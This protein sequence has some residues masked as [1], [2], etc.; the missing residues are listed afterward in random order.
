MISHSLSFLT[1]LLSSQFGSQITQFLSDPYSGGLSIVLSV[2]TL[3]SMCVLF[4]KAERYWWEAL[5]PFYN[6]YVM[7]KIAKMSG[8]NFL[9]IFV[10]IANFIFGIVLTVKFTNTFNKGTLFIL[11]MLFF[12]FIFYPILAFGGSRYAYVDRGYT[13]VE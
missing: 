10:P 12:P 5:I 9:W 11:G 4:S 1:P 2:I 13:I 6:I 3:V 8:W 7:C